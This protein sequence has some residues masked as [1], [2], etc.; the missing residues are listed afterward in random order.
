MTK[1]KIG[2]KQELFESLSLYYKVV[3]L[4]E[5]LGNLLDEQETDKTV[6]TDSV[7]IVGVG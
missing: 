5:D 4:G 7:N 6:S 2:K 1:L 3:I